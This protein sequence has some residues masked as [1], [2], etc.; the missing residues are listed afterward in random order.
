MAS[1]TQVTSQEG[2]APSSGES[3]PLVSASTEPL[4]K[5]VTIVP[6]PESPQDPCQAANAQE[7][8]QALGVHKPEL[9]GLVSS[10][11]YFSS[12]GTKMLAVSQQRRSTYGE[13]NK[14]YVEISAEL[15][16]RGSRVVSFSQVIATKTE[17]AEAAELYTSLPPYWQQQVQ[18]PQAVLVIKH[19]SF[20][21]VPGFVKFENDI[22]SDLAVQ[23]AQGVE[24]RCRSGEACKCL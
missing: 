16:E 19:H 11:I 9:A 5:Q 10:E 24:L 15:A 3:T 12:T 1:C 23:L 18:D 13:E 14:T 21:K 22:A 8:W 20:K 6:L 17:F 2:A 4:P 7:A